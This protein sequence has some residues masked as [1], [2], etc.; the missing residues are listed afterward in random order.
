MV[1]RRRHPIL[2]LGSVAVI[3][4]GLRGA[5]GLAGATFDRFYYAPDT[6]ADA[7]L[8][9]CVLAFITITTDARWMKPAAAVSAATLTVTSFA[10]W[11]ALV[12]LLFP[13]AFES[14]AL[15]ACAARYPVPVLEWRP[16]VFTGK[17]SYG[18][19]LWNVPAAIAL[20]LW[21]APRWVLTV[22]LFGVSFTLAIVSWY[23]IERPFMRRP[24]NVSAATFAEVVAPKAEVHTV[25]QESN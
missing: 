12:W 3:S 13:L 10:A 7:I 5:L 24:V 22:A 19:H 11:P 16:F 6:R 20:Q 8:I 2:I 18:L 14:A 9:G 23:V 1:V 4:G 25:R 15:V 21:D 17:I